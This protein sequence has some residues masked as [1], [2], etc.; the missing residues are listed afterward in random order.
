MHTLSVLH[1]LL[2]KAVPTI[3]TVRLASLM[4]AVQAVLSGAQVSVTSLGRHVTNAAFVK[5]KIKRMDRLLSNHKLHQER[6]SLYRVITQQ[7][8]QGLPQPVILVDWSPLT[9]DQE[10]QLLRASLP[11]KGRSLTLYE[12]IHPR[13]KLG[14]RN[15]QQNFMAVLK[16]LL[17]PCCRPI[18]VADSGF[19]VPFYRFVEQTLEWQWVGRIRN[20]DF[21]ASHSHPKQW[22]S[23]TS[24]YHRATTRP[25]LV[26]SV[27]WVRKHPLSVFLVLV[28]TAR[29]GRRKLTVAGK[30]SQ[31]NHSLKQA[32]REREPWLL[33]ASLSLLSFSPRQIVKLY[34]TR[35]QIEEGFR[36]TKSDP[37][38]LGL[39]KA[40]RINPQRR[41]ILLLIA[42]LAIW[43][44]WCIGIAAKGLPLAKQI[45]VNSSSKKPAYS[46][47]F[48]ARLLLQ[49]STFQITQHQMQQSLIT[50]KLYMDDVVL[51]D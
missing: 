21:I 31:S 50:I 33:V 28:R 41:A 34:R 4:A 45:R 24:I 47:I 30:T 43:V 6:L 25:V 10:Q 40:T 2:H 14:S 26:G 13:S 23:A 16:S 17:P 20:R 5:H 48:L 7:L 22:F 49:H 27:W 42:A 18:V 36:D 29:K 8:L 11:V 39:A 9:A 1:K 32:Q 15:V 46:V 35:M 38:G 12:E 51:C 3:H 37:Y 19:R 44:L